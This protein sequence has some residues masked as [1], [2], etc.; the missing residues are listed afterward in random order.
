MANKMFSVTNA[1][2]F[3]HTVNGTRP[4]VDPQLKIRFPCSVMVYQLVNIYR[5]FEKQQCLHLQDVILQRCLAPEIKALW[6]S[7]SG[8]GGLEVA[9]WPLVPKFAVSHPAEAVVFL[10]RKILSRRSHVVALP[11]V[12]DPQNQREIRHLGKI[13]GHFSPTV[14]P[15]AAGCSRVVTR[16]KTPG[17]E[18]RNV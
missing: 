6:S 18:S 13:P 12:K 16:V 7:D 3:C 14:S 15:S 5:R 9:C 10:G 2:V 8:F 11:H 17:G 1:S 4:P